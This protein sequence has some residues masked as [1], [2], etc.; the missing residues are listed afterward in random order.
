MQRW[1]VI[2]HLAVQLVTVEIKRRFG[3][4]ETLIAA[5]LNGGPQR[6]KTLEKD[7]NHQKQNQHDRRLPASTG[8]SS[9]LRRLLVRLLSRARVALKLGGGRTHSTNPNFQRDSG[10]AEKTHQQ[11]A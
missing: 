2:P 11:T 6:K 7:K 4:R 1:L 8:G 5:N 10:S 9:R 3:E